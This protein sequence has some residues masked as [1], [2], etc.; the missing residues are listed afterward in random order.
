MER[1]RSEKERRRRVICR[2]PRFSTAAGHSKSSTGEGA[3]VYLQLAAVRSVLKKNRTIHE[4][5]H[6][7]HEF[8]I[9]SEN[10]LDV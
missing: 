6:Y 5:D 1:G 9:N 7:D 10:A 3:L 8:P 4:N 2:A